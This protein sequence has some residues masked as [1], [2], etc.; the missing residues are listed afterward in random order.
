MIGGYHAVQTW[1]KKSY[2]ATIFV[3][4]GKR[5]VVKL[6][7]DGLQNVGEARQILKAMNLKGIEALQ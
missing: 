1:E 2:A 5:F 3:F 4:P 6:Q 7:A